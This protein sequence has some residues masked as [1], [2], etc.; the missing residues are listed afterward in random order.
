MPEIMDEHYLVSSLDYTMTPET[1]PRM[2][3]EPNCLLEY[4]GAHLARRR[5]SLTL[6]MSNPYK[7]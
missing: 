1:Y 3:R 2:R 7:K 6:P 5:A 4:Y